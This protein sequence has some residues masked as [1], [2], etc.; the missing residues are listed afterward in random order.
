MCACVLGR[1]Q[2]GHRRTLPRA[3]DFPEVV[4]ILREVAA[5]QKLVSRS[6]KRMSSFAADAV[7]PSRWP[8]VSGGALKEEAVS[9]V[10]KLIPYDGRSVA[11]VQ[12]GAATGDWATRAELRAAAGPGERAASWRA[13]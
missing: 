12:R 6:T 13:G 4:L 7:S 9:A 8:V 1:S 10:V 5:S 3:P 11:L 2:R